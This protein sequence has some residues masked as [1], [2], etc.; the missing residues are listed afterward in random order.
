MNDAPDNARPRAA[1][2]TADVALHCRPGKA[3]NYLT[4]PYRLENRGPGD[5]YVMDAIP[6]AEP[7]TDT[8]TA[9]DQAAVVV[10]RGDAE[11]VI[12]KY[13]ALLPSDRRIIAPVAPLTRLLRTGEA[14][15]SELRIPVPLAETSPYAPDLR[16]RD[17]EVIEL[18]AVVFAIAYW[19]AGTAGVFAMPSEHDADRM[20]IVARNLNGASKLA[21]QRFPTHGLQLF[22]RTDAFPRSA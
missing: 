11:A 18:Q 21:W 1:A 22:K 14:W 9:D 7:G 10:L 5:V 12:G 20:A 3:G 16:L 6:R 13:L 2:P 4:F 15:E 19:V 17:Y 8:T